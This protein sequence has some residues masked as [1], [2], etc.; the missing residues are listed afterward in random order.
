MAQEKGG[1]LQPSKGGEDNYTETR[2]HW[3]SAWN[4]HLEVYRPNV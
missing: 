2:S 4:C 1:G 3:L